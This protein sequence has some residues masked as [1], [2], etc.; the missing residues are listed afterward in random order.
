VRSEIAFDDEGKD[1][2]KAMRSLHARV[3]VD[4]R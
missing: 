2:E 4:L 3:V 1:G